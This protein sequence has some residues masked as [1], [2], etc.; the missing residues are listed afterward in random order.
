MLRVFEE[1]NQPVV[2]LN[3]SASVELE[4]EVEKEKIQ[5]KYRGNPLV[6]KGAII[7]PNRCHCD[8]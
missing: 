1:H 2:I 3:L 7:H 4:I 8:L 5:A 6:S